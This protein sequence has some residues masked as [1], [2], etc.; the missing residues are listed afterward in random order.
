MMKPVKILARFAVPLFTA[1]LVVL[2]TLSSGGCG[3][4]GTVT[5]DPNSPDLKKSLSRKYPEM[6]N[7]VLGK[8]KKSGRK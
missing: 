1:A 8:V 3:S 2:L 5:V 4:G 6:E 7:P